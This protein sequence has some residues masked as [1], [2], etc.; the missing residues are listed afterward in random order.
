MQLRDRDYG[1]KR[2]KLSF[3]K[4]M[5]DKGELP[6]KKINIKKIRKQK[7]NRFRGVNLDS[8]FN[9]LITYV[10]VIYHSVN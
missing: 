7:I 2:N 8:Y 6:L 5:I 9:L 4:G 3:R 1:R 10:L